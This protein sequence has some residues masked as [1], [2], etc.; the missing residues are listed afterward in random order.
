MD[1]DEFD[2]ADE[3]PGCAVCDGDLVPLGT[4]GCRQHFRCR[5]CGLDQSHLTEED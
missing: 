1:P 2:I 5:H 3:Q 4:L